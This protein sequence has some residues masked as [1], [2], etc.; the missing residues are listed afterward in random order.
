MHPNIEARF[1]HRI[2][3][4]EAKLKQ[5]FQKYYINRQLYENGEKE[6][7]EEKFTGFSSDMTEFLNKRKRLIDDIN[8]NKQF[9]ETQKSKSNKF[10]TVRSRVF[11]AQNLGKYSK[12]T[13]AG[14]A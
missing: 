1:L 7:E 6:E 12:T 8:T 5:L 4:N 2:K 10:K 14:T 3:S 9:G 13:F 11:S